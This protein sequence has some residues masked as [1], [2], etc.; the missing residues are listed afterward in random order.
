ARP[1][2]S[3]KRCCSGSRSSEGPDPRA[4]ARR[5]GPV[6]MGLPTVAIVGR[7]NV[8]KSSLFN[9]LL[10]RRHAIVSHVPGVTRNRLEARCEWVGR[11]FI[12]IDTGGLVPGD[13]EPLVVQVRRQAERAIADASAVLFIV[14]AVA[15]LT[16][17]DEEIA[18]VLRRS[19]RPVLVV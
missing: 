7:P 8:G 5:V 16:A 11:E 18:D 2:G 10:T 12:L 13:A 17:Q 14:D 19:R 1:T 3:S 4:A 15:G 9:R 6:T